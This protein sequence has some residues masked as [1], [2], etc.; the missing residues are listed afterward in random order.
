M[1]PNIVVFLSDQQRADTLGCNGQPLPVTPNLNAFART[2]VNYRNAFTNQP[3]C[4]PAR[5]MM[6]TG[7]YPTQLNC[8]RNGVPLPTNADTLSKRMRGAG[9]RVAYVGKWH[10]AS[11]KGEHRYE[12]TA[13]PPDRRG[14]YTDYWVASDVLEFT[15]HGYGGYLHDKDGNRVDFD[16]YRTD[17]VTDYA[18]RYIQEYDSTEPFF[19]FLS[20]IEPHHQ[21][22]RN[23]YE[24]PEGSREKFRDFVLPED[25][26]SL[27]GD[28]G[29]WYPDYLGCCNA[30][31]RNFGRVLD[32]LGQK[33]I[34]ENTV[35]VYASD[36]GCHFRTRANEVTEGGYDDYKRNAFEGTIRVPLLIGGPGFAKNV[37]EERV[38]SLI[39]LPRTLLTAAGAELPPGIQGR[40][41]QTMREPWVNEAYIQISESF[42]GRALRTQ[43]YKYVLYAPDKNP[44][45]DSGSEV[46]RERYLFDLAADPLEKN[47]LLADP[48]YQ[49]A[50]LALAERIKA[51]AREAGEPAFEIV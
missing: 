17:C 42:V 22:D 29:T 27:P 30:L 23:S 16:G 46:Y 38:V 15:S 32:A 33:G 37:R 19:L 9:Y 49:D 5:A 14:G 7:L 24:G 39:D 48:A 18:L 20:H 44:A 45:A 34:L 28:Y 47:N 35:V 2:A 13:V 43:R 4:G 1:R 25:L 41:L 21:N 31:D 11:D 12:R 6:Q 51:R 3:V 10:L 50:R 8:F 36:H 40:A 26:K